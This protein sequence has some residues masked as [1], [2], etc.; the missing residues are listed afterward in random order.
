[1]LRPS[2]FETTATRWRL[3]YLFRRPE[4]DQ[5][6]GQRLFRAE[7]GWLFAGFAVHAQ[8]A[9]EHS[10][11]RRHPA[12]EYVQQALSRAAR[13]ISVEISADHSSGNDFAAE[14]GAIPHL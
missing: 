10:A 2:H 4:R 6:F 11:S 1:M 14:L 5:R 8:S 12:D 3:E 7:A 9:R 13:P